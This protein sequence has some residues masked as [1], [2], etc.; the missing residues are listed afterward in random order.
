[1]RPTTI[2]LLACSFALIAYAAPS[3][4]QARAP[5]GARLLGTNPLAF[6]LERQPRLFVTPMGE[7]L[8][9][10]RFAQ[11]VDSRVTWPADTALPDLALHFI[12]SYTSGHESYRRSGVRIDLAHELGPTRLTGSATL[13]SGAGAGPQQT[14]TLTFGAIF[15]VLRFEVRTAWLRSAT[16]QN[17][18]HIGDDIS[19]PAIPRPASKISGNYTDGELHA[20]RNLD[21]ISL[22]VTGGYRFGGEAWGSR[23]WLF[24]EAGVPAPVWNRLS[25]IIAGGVRPE[26]VEFAQPGGRFAQ[27]GLR[28]EIGSP[29]ES[30]TLPPPV[31][32]PGTNTAATTVV[33]LGLDH[34]LIRL[35]QPARSS[36]ELKGDITDWEVVP[37][38]RSMERDD[39]WETT[40]H[41]P[42]GY[43]HVNIRVDGGEWITPPGLVAVPDRFGG[44][45]GILNL[46]TSQE[47]ADAQS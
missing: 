9:G 46:P 47:V 2:T 8:A 3:L 28:L 23:R 38:R 18:R 11:R 41:K 31:S 40:V 1:M 22:G 33:Q 7:I 6:L 20:L 34:Y 14:I 13:A 26:R 42:A 4:A 37:L 5:D 21:R 15:P 45:T 39:L 44:S 35:Y 24:G 12:V 10:G 16:S 43:Y 36:V 29:R 17:S 27:F 30:V 32:P 25:I 19:I